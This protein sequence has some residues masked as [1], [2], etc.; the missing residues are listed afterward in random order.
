MVCAKCFKQS[1]Y[2]PY[3]R[4]LGSLSVFDQ[5]F[6]L[7]CH[8]TLGLGMSLLFKIPLLHMQPLNTYTYIHSINRTLS[9]AL[10]MLLVHLALVVLGAL[11]AHKKNKSLGHLGG[12]VG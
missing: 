2:S 5:F 4:D 12:L 11:G 1:T 10:R 6:V 7:S 9:N 3:F 8:M